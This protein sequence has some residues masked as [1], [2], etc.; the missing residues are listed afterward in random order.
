MKVVK[1]ENKRVDQVVVKKKKFKLDFIKYDRATNVK[2][3]SSVEV[4]RDA[5]NMDKFRMNPRECK[6]SLDN[7][8]SMLSLSKYK[9][10][11]AGLGLSNSCYFL[12][13]FGPRKHDETGKLK[14]IMKT[15]WLMTCSFDFNLKGTRFCGGHN[16]PSLLV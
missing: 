16:L 12:A 1:V 7:A 11:A 4:T 10:N 15:K 3:D 9:H 2:N 6:P 13:H 8:M 5:I 14:D